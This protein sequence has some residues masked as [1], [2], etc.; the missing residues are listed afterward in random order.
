M[1]RTQRQRR[2]GEGHGKGMQLTM[3]TRQGRI[4]GYKC[5][6]PTLLSPSHACCH[7]LDRAASWQ[8]REVKDW[9]RAGRVS[10]QL[11]LGQWHS[12]VMFEK[13]H[14]GHTGEDGSKWERG[15]RREARS[16]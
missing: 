6:E 13:V 2:H 9:V 16:L 1:I 7:P 3:V 15:R 5:P 8:S 4:Q 12:Q 14:S 11:S 10:A